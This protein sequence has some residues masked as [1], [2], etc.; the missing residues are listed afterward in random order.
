MRIR[1]PPVLLAMLL[2]A[3]CVVPL[4][5]QQASRNA[6]WARQIFQATNQARARHGLPPLTW[7]P[8]LAAAAQAHLSVMIHQPDLSHDYP[9][10]PPLPARA[11]QAGAHFETVA[12]NIAMGYSVPA[13]QNEWMH[14]PAH[15]ANILNPRLNAAG[16]AIIKRRGNFYA[17]VDFAA[18]V[19]Q[20]DVSQSTQQV[21]RLLQRI[22][23]TPGGSHAAAEAACAPDYRLSAGTPVRLLVRFTTSDLTQLPPQAISQIE[24]SGATHAAVAICPSDGSQ[25]GFTTYRV[26]L[27]LY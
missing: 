1:K 23:I 21:A 11:A 24:S 22:G 25:P 6:N 14:S 13:I 8:S 27:L 15:R 10:E 26:A 12:E 5:A 20:R 17:V 18:A 16:V 3:F 2:L 9:G 7:S 4:H 19:Q